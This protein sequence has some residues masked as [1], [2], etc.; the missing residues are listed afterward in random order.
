MSDSRI[1]H[2][3]N[4]LAYNRTLVFDNEQDAQLLLVCARDRWPTAALA[5]CYRITIPDD[6]TIQPASSLL[7]SRSG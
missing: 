3:M 4:E 1:D 5:R 7:G 2:H 6:H